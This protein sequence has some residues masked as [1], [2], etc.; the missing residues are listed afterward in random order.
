MNR[1]DDR[2]TLRMAKA[3]A[4]AAV[5]PWLI[6]LVL[7]S[8]PVRWELSHTYEHWI[9][10]VGSDLPALTTAV[11]LPVLG[12]GPSRPSGLLVR[13]VFWTVLWL[14]PAPLL[15]LVWRSDAQRRLLEVLVLGGGGYAG[16][17][18]LFAIVVAMGLWLPFSL[19]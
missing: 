9:E 7:V 14:G 12:I 18:V 8:G 17:V 13:W 4:T 3:A 10:G 15:L 6:A 16:V 19:L 5:V 11:A 2:T 1:S